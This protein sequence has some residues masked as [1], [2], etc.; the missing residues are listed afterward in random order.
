MINPERLLKY[1]YNYSLCRYCKEKYFIKRHKNHLFCSEKCVIRYRYYI[2][3]YRPYKCKSCKIKNIWHKG[4][5]ID[6]RLKYNEVL[7]KNNPICKKCKRYMSKKNKYKINKEIIR[8]RYRCYFCNISYVKNAKFRWHKKINCPHCYKQEGIRK[9][10]YYV[11]SIHH[12][13]TRY[14][15]KNCNKNFSLRN[16]YFRM[17]TSPRIINYILKFSTQKINIIPKKFDN[18]KY[19]DNL[20]PSSRFVVKIIKKKFKRK[21]SPNFVCSLIK[22]YNIINIRN[23]KEN[24]WTFAH[25]K[26]EVI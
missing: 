14:Y 20:Y 4:K 22:K 7:K 16:L 2:C 3:K 17:R 25:G 18:R 10:K 12:W 1:M 21:I 11:N 8:K 5:C 9:G 23:R 19:P 26:K 15:C 24:P 13:K 6:C